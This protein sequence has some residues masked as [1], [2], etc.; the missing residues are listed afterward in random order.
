MLESHV[1]KAAVELARKRAGMDEGVKAGKARH[2]LGKA[3]SSRVNKLFE[4]D[5]M[6]K[7]LKDEAETEAELA[8]L[9]LAR[10][11]KEKQ[12]AALELE[13]AL[14]VLER[15]TIHRSRAW[16]WSARCPPASGS[17]RRRS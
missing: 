16:W 11:R 6:S 13:K 15:R 12:L 8:R 7:E 3:K 5:A 4:Q 14:A 9:E 1:E 2:Q 10:A 17:T